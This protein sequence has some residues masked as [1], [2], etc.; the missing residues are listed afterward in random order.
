MIDGFCSFDL[1]CVVAVF[2]VGLLGWKIY[3]LVNF[4]EVEF[5]CLGEVFLGV[6]TYLYVISSV[7]DLRICE[8]IR[9]RRAIGV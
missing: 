6:Q 3:Y 2:C 4:L 5:F 9:Y 7:Y 8:A 1:N